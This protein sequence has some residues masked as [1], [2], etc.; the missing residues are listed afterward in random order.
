VVAH[1]QWN[2]KTGTAWS[3]PYVDVAGNTQTVAGVS[4]IGG[5]RPGMPNVVQTTNGQ[6]I[7]TFEFFGGGQNVQRKITSDPLNFR[8]ASS[9][10]I[11]SLPVTSGSPSLA[12]GG[13]PVIVR[14]NDGRLIYNAAG[15]GDVWV[16][17]SGSSTGA[18]T[19]QYTTI[20]AGYSRNLTWHARTGR[21]VILS[22]GWP[23]GGL[24]SH[25]DID[26]GRSGGQYFQLINRRSGKAALRGSW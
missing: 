25:A 10:D 23:N 18:W 8:S 2:G 5:G 7:Q 24:I 17:P 3:V 13:S 26:F 22:A 9:A 16:N 6:W 1:R 19:R 21:V 14:M 20:G 4:Q 12:V 11:S 15:S